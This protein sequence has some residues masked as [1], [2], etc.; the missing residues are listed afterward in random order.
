MRVI[1]FPVVIRRIAMLPGDMSNLVAC[2]MF[3]THSGSGVGEGKGRG[4]W[5]REGWGIGSENDV[6][7]CLVSHLTYCRTVEVVDFYRINS[8]T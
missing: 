5:D 2:T 1:D 3:P 4:Y 6:W 7:G 8:A